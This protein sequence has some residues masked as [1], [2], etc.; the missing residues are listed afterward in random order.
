MQHWPPVQGDEIQQFDVLNRTDEIQQFDVLNR[1]SA[2][3]LGVHKQKKKPL[4]QEDFLG[5]GDHDVKKK[6]RNSQY[7]AM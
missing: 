2:R 7:F 5:L 3:H 4:Q 1:T 6:T